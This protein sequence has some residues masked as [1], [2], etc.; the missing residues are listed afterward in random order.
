MSILIKGIDMPQT[1]EIMLIGITSDGKA[2][3][4]IS[5]APLGNSVKIETQAV[6]KGKRKCR[7]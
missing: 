1:N 4:R 5:K 7:Y 3:V 2:Q 6:Q